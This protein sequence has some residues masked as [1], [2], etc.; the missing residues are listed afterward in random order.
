M[1]CIEEA[2]HM[3]FFWAGFENILWFGSGRLKDGYGTWSLAQAC[4]G[5]EAYNHAMT[6]NDRIDNL[7][8]N[9]M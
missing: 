4:I 3:P 1:C 5:D 6:W 9:W 8:A 2:V 7:Y